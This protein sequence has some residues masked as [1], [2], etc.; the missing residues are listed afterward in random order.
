MSLQQEADA[1]VLS[2]YATATVEDLERGIANAERMAVQL[3]GIYRPDRKTREQVVALRK[4]ADLLRA[5]L[6]R[7]QAVTG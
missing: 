6:S 7:R 5:E 3:G 4:H 2:L 1:Q